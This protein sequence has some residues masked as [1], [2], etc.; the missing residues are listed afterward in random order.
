V[1]GVVTCSRPDL[2]VLLVKVQPSCIDRQYV[3]TMCGGFTMYNGHQLSLTL[4]R[5]GRTSETAA[6][7]EHPVF[8]LARF[9]TTVIFAIDH[10]QQQILLHFP[11]P[12][13]SWRLHLS[14]PDLLC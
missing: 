13:P 9:M 10:H 14:L 1:G 2:T 8:L 11:S 5:A 6:R 3:N 4:R 12:S 7:V